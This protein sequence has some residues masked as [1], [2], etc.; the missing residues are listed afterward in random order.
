M[1]AAEDA[2]AVT[3]DAVRQSREETERMELSL[4]RKLETRPGIEEIK[5]CALDDHNIAQP[6]AM[7]GVQFILEHFVRMMI[8]QKEI[9]V[10]AQEIAIDAFQP[11]NFICAVDRGGV[12]FGC[13]A[14]AILTV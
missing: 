6:C 4:S 11:A 9:A 14:C 1:R 8:R 3:R 10:N 13:V 2:A 12:T 5:R 7:T